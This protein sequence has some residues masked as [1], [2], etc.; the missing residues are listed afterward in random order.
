MKW[1]KRL[2]YFFGILYA[3]VCVVLYFQQ[4]RIIF[5]PTVL[6][7]SFQFWEGEEVYVPVEEDI[8]LHALWLKQPSTRGVVLYWHGNR[9]SNRRC[10]RQAENLAG[11][12]YDVF[13]PDY[14]GYGKSDGHISSEKQLFADAQTVYDWL[15][16]HYREDQIV[17][18][19]Y[20]LGSGV[21]TYLGTTNH[22]Q[23]LCLVA[24]YR[25][26][27]EMKNLILPV[28]PSFLV[29][30][31]LRNDLRLGNVKVPVTLFHGTQ[32]ELIPFEHSLFLQKLLPQTAQLI[33]LDGKGHRGA[34]FSS[35]L[36]EE[37]HYIIKNNI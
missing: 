24:P 14:R 17:V 7:D 3:L 1:I 34:I 5:N 10:L 11:L 19:G 30:Y 6:E 22:P 15:K 9:G 33:S 23:H 21:A 29:K 20:S 2:A 13:M 35:V 27:V 31:P 12:G 16:Q 36:R 28:V 18:L 37:L 25:S 26:M 32:D 4:E 8:D